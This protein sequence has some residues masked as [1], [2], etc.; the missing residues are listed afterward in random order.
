LV[1]VGDAEPDAD[2]RRA[3]RVYLVDLEGG[4]RAVAQGP[5]MTAPAW[6]PQGDLIAYVAPAVDDGG[7]HERVWV[8]APG[9]GEPRCLTAALDRSAAGS[10]VTDMRAGFGARLCWSAGG[11]RVF[12]L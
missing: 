8:V 7:R 11:D 10:V 5:Q 9:G 4:R 12:F 6:S 3:S 2:L 1:V